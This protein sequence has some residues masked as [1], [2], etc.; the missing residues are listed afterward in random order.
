MRVYVGMAMAQLETLRDNGLPAPVHAHAVTP[1]LREWYVEGDQEELEYA[2]SV[3]AARDSLRLLAASPAD[4][5]RRV[6]V[7]ADVPDDV[8]RALVLDVDDAQRSAVQ[9]DLTLSL[10]AVAS[11]HVDDVDARDDVLAAVAALPDAEAGDD[12]A[13]FTVDGAE[14]H[15]LLWYDVSELDDVLRLP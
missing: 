15:D 7:A 12:D 6:V 10:D 2:A 5:W 9:L 4:A 14:G 13:R 3:D 1:A 11:I 8:V